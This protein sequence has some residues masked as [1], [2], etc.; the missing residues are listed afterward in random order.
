MDDVSLGLLPPPPP[1][2]IK[3]H[4]TA[5]LCVACP[6][7]PPPRICGVH[8]PQTLCPPDSWHPLPPL[9]FPHLAP[10]YIYTD[11]HDYFTVLC[12]CTVQVH[13]QQPLHVVTYYPPW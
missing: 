3:I 12:T 4:E 9:H 2:S 10:G 11:G 8:A 5:M 7:P 6:R 1:I 13:S